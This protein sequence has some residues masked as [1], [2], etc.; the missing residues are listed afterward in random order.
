MSKVTDEMLTAFA[1]GELSAE[2]RAAVEAA[3]AEDAELRQALRV[4]Q[5]LRARLNAHYDPIADEPLP[6][7][8]ETLLATGEGAA[9]V[10]FARARERRRGF[11]WPQVA[12]MAASLAAGVLVGQFATGPASGP[13]A[14]EGG[15]MLARGGLA[16]ILETRLASAQPA[17]VETRIGL[18]FADSAGRLCRAFDTPGLS[19]IA[20]KEP[21]GWRL[22]MTVA[23]AGAA[24]SEY[25]QAGSPLV[26]EQAQAMMAGA[27]LDAAAERRARDRG[28]RRD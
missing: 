9:V 16:E 5:A 15:V 6:T 10:D 28:W 27:P 7:R 3:L 12:A 17:G 4:Q 26:M 8:L 19:G 18:S 23:G 24:T 25:R 21:A 13:V 11:A 22:V 2:D 14:V 20:C 1:D